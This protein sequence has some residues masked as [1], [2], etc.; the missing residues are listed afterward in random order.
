MRRALITIITLALLTPLGALGQDRSLLPKGRWWKMP[1]VSK[2]LGLT[3]EQQ[4]KLDSIFASRSKE[5]IDLKGETE[6][7]GIELRSQLEATHVLPDGVMNAAKDLGN[8]RS[9]LF[10]KEVRMMLDMR[11]ELTDEQWT[12]LRTAMDAQ[13]KRMR[14]QRQ[15]P[16]Q[17]PDGRRPQN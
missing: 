1:E 4:S 12:T 5:L 17:R 16:G 14:E 6:K 10:Q 7:H 9:L 13:M 3:A 2:K 11:A 15:R 8:A